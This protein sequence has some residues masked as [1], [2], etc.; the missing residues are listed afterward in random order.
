MS[1]KQR[2]GY[3]WRGTLQSRNEF[4]TLVLGGAAL[5][6]LS[7][8][9]GRQM[10][11][12]ALVTNNPFASTAVLAILCLGAAQFLIF[13]GRLIY[14]PIHCRTE[15]YGG[16]NNLARAKLGNQMWP[17]ALMALSFFAFAGLFSIGA[18]L[19]LLRM[20]IGGGFAAASAAA[21]AQPILGLD[22]PNDTFVL[23]WDSS[24]GTDIRF[25]KV[26]QVAAANFDNPAFTLKKLNS[27][28]AADLNITWRAEIS[29]LED[30]VKKS[31]NF[32]DVTF[33]DNNG[34]FILQNKHGAFGYMLT[35]KISYNVAFLSKD[36]PIYSPPSINSIIALYFAANMPKQFGER[37]APLIIS[38]F[39][40]WNIPE[41]GQTEQFR[42]TAIATN[43]KAPTSP[44]QDMSGVIDFRVEKVS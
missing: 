14:W 7:I 18:I 25:R 39:V 38:V 24:R 41:G 20:P 40:N 37:T 16:L 34:Y 28:S 9:A 23:Q 6:F 22:A 44:A 27:V 21:T 30:I 5:F 15:P 29:G 10:T 19:F 43:T 26:D 35:N 36:T 42:I 32:K 12:P 13:I 8:F 17:I 31:D 2:L 3:A 1:F 33:T 4:F 11:L